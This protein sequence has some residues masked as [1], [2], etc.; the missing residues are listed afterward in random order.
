MPQNMQKKPKLAEQELIEAQTYAE[1]DDN[2][3][4][5]A[6][7]DVEALAS[8]S[9]VYAAALDLLKHGHQPKKIAQKLLEKGVV[10]TRPEANRL[11]LKVAKENPQ[12]QRTNAY[13]LF[14]VAGVITAVGAGFVG[15]RWL[16]GNFA[17][18]S[19]YVLFFIAAWFAYKGYD[20]LK[21][22]DKKSSE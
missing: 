7:L 16:D 22:D 20:N 13:I 11:A 14:G 5:S 9:P 18:S 2:A 3:T 15:L 1:A 12:E 4:T 6:T 10:K 17:L 19:I 21:T 8:D